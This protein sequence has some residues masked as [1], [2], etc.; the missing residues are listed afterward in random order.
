MSSPYLHRQLSDDYSQN[1][2]SG[3]HTE[4]SYYDPFVLFLANLSIDTA[5]DYRL[6]NIGLLIG[7]KWPSAPVGTFD[8]GNFQ[9]VTDTSGTTPPAQVAYGFGSSSDPLIGGLLTDATPG[10]GGYIPSSKYRTLLKAIA[11]VKYNGLSLKIIVEL[12]AQFSSNFAI[13]FSSYGDVQVVF[14]TNIGTGNLWILQ[15]AMNAVCTAPK[16]FFSYVP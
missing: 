15:E 1:L 3:L 13:S 14:S 7:Y 12:S 10:I 6:E 16:V 9:F 11:M 4:T 5:D 8:D 2:M